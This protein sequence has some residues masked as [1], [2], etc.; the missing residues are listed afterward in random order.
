M[1]SGNILRKELPIAV[2]GAGA[3]GLPAAVALA[4]NGIKVLLLE[5]GKCFD[6]A[7]IPTNRYDYELSPPPWEN[8]PGNENWHGPVRLQGASGIG[9]STLLFQAVAHLPPIAIF[10]QWGLPGRTIKQ[11][12]R[13][14]SDFLQI[15]GEVQPAHELNPV[16]NHLLHCARKIG[17]NARPAPV[18]ILSEPY[19]GRPACVR[20]GL[21]VFGCRVGDKGSTDKTWL[22]RGEATGRIK[23][24]TDTKADFLELADHERVKAVHVI[25]NGKREKIEVS[26]VVLSAGALETPY[27]LRSSA[28]TLAPNGIGGQN[29]G[30]YLTTTNWQ[31]LL[32][33]VPGQAEGYDGI[34]IDIL[35]EEHK[36]KGILLCQGRNLAGIV[37]PVTAARF[38]ALSHQSLKVRNWMRE[39][40]PAL[41]GL[42]GF[43]E[44]ST[45]SADGIVDFKNR[46]FEM[47]L[48]Q[49]DHDSLAEI[50]RLLHTW[51]SSS[52]AVVLLELNKTP[53]VG[54]LL[55]GTCR[56][57][58]DPADSATNPDGRLHGYRNIVVSDSSV[59]GRGLITDP[60][61]SL[62]VLGFYFGS[63]L[64]ARFSE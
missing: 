47:T 12:G 7:N 14:L 56:V 53:Y 19:K 37:G 22:P 52:G 2:I 57:G 20:C 63:R 6:Y 30:K 11:L 3:G 40:Y 32:V 28:Q 59:L 62:Q 24:L 9:G 61:L 44:S 23:V 21:C 10:E 15:A 38:C 64:A 31:S 27:L 29:V 51:A 55:R 34:P 4:E 25:S 18:A 50:S 16:S 8:F 54:S 26:A 48:R 36:N 46:R 41:A 33:S 43:S 13:E 49:S 58:P 60:S 5:R 35:V 42:A 1:I 17:W 45:S 39:N